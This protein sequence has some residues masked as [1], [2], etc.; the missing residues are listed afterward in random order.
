MLIIT[1]QNKRKYKDKYVGSQ[2]FKIEIDRQ[3]STGQCFCR[4]IL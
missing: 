3:V 2:H 1:K 4:V